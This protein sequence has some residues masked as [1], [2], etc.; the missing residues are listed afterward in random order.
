MKQLS[1]V[2]SLVQYI[3]CFVFLFLFRVF[4]AVAPKEFRPGWPLTIAVTTHQNVSGKVFVNVALGP[5]EDE[6][7]V[8]SAVSDSLN[9]GS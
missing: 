7:D 6:I 2:R 4:F 1:Y 8:Y 5:I 3:Y 9:P